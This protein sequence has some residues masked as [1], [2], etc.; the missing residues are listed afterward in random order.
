[1]TD[2]TYSKYAVCASP[3][4]NSFFAL[5]DEFELRLYVCEKLPAQQ[6][7]LMLLLS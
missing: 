7:T 2:Y 1:M 5:R 4:S 6:Q 3:E